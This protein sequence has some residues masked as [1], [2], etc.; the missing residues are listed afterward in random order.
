MFLKSFT[1]FRKYGGDKSPYSS[2]ALGSSPSK[3]GMSISSDTCTHAQKQSYY[4]QE[5]KE[6]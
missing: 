2:V 6:E 3:T 1:F 5:R 4:F